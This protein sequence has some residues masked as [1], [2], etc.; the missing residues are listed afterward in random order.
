[1]KSDNT[2]HNIWG[3]NGRKKTV[4]WHADYYGGCHDGAIL[5]FSAGVMHLLHMLLVAVK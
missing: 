2:E 4:L 1:M 5:L 3:K